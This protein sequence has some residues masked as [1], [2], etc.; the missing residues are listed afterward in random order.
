ME[1]NNILNKK[2][3]IIIISILAGVLCISMMILNY[4]ELKKDR[5][6]QAEIT[7]NFNSIKDILEYYECKHIKTENSEIE[8]FSVDIYT[9]FKY[10]LYDEEKNNEDFY[11]NIIE[12]IAKVQNY[13]NFRLIDETKDEKIEIKVFGD[14]KK[15]KKVIINGIED[16]FIYM[17]SQID[18]KKYSKIEEIDAQIESPEILRCIDNNWDKATEF[19]TR[20]AIFQ[21]YY[22][23]FEEGISVRKISGKIYNVVFTDKYE[24]SV[25]N[26]LTVKSSKDLIKEK[27]GEPAFENKNGTL[28]GYKCKDIYVFFS[29]NEIS[30]YRNSEEDYDK[31][32]EIIDKFLDKEYTFLELMNELTYIW[33]DYETYEY[34]EDTV[35]ISYPNKGI[36]VKIN[37]KDE[38]GIVIYNNVQID[39]ELIKKYL[40]HTEFIS[41]R[42]KDNIYNAE[43]R[44]F[45]KQ[46]KLNQNCIEYQNNYEQ[47][48]NRNRGE[49]YKYYMDI[50]TSGNIKATYFI[51]QSED[52]FNNQLIE[53]IDSYIWIND[54]TFIYSKAN[55]GIYKFDLVNGEKSVVLTGDENFQIN[56]YENG[57]LTYDYQKTINL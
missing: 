56:S 35:F 10:D 25:I 38:D 55:R 30:I 51:S 7:G 6:K 8:D 50:D 44:R 57:I 11:N 49:I 32:F 19:G 23:Y 3:F 27:L 9:S 52:Y 16:Y 48:D 21:N 33:P 14:G 4:M 29:N 43:L 12:K 46:S 18:A 24:Q 15:I 17:D 53:N 47:E 28:I 40:E 13:Q 22:I 41:N 54:T 1:K 26:G 5:I 39:K 2:I 36:D 34:S 37:Y 31:F 20:E 45:S 42:K